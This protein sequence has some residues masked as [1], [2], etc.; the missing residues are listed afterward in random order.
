MDIYSVYFK[1]FLPDD[2]Y[3][4]ILDYEWSSK[5]WHTKLE[6][7]NYTI[8]NKFIVSRQ[9]SKPHRDEIN[10]VYIDYSIKWNN[11]IIF[12]RRYI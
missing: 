5:K 4:K 10:E 3:N 12:K 8:R 11:I 7:D 2:M 9:I 6:L 1:Q